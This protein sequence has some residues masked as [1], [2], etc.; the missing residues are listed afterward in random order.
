MLKSYKPYAAILLLLIIVIGGFV[1]SYVQL[2]TKKI[3]NSIYTH[4]AASMRKNVKLMI[5][6]KQKSTLAI[7]LSLANDKNLIEQI[8]QNKI[9]SDSYKDL[10]DKL[11][12]QTLY[13]NVWIQIINKD[14]VSL[15]RS[16]SDLKGDLLHDVRKDLKN[17]LLHKTVNYSI[18]ICRFDLSIRTIVPLFENKNFIGILEV[19]T[20]FNSIANS[21]KDS[22]VGSVVVVKKEFTDKIKFPLTNQ[23]INDHYVANLNAPE[24]LTNYLKT[25]GPTNYFNNSYKIEN[26]YII[27]SYELK[28]SQSQAIGYFIMFKKLSDVQTMNL[29][30]FVFKWMSVFVLLGLL[31][32]FIISNIILIKN[33]NQKK[34]YKSILDTASNIVIV[35]DGKKLVDTNKA[36][37]KYFYSYKTIDEFL[38]D[39]DCVC[40]LFAKEKGYLQQP[41]NNRYWIEYVIRNSDIVHKAKILYLDE[42]YYFSVTAALISED[43]KHY[44]VVLSDITKEEQYQKELLI[45]SIKDTLT[46]IY[47]RHYFDQKIDDEIFRVKRYEYPLSLIMLDIDFFKNVNDDHGHDVGDSVLI[48]YTKLISSL[49]RKTDIFCRMGGEEFII[50]LPHT[51]INEAV[52][53]SEKL[54]CEIEKY[55]KILPITMS[56]GVT[57]YKTDET[58]QTFLKRV[59][60]ALYKAKQS[61]RNKVIV[62]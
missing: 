14:A 20:H 28:N 32:L 41:M 40:D 17:I 12:Q 53:I 24:N 31:V 2:N 45:L 19:I 29:E 8:K 55:K 13:K 5:L 52:G 48:E 1:F 62:S 61:G 25:H 18:D 49:L 16:W 7:A 51:D 42:I 23:F 37:F 9:A 21:L 26:G 38:K 36:F 39:Y 47:N 3:Q 27:V 60:E 57:Q 30:F 44:S 11:T 46:D 43:P 6:Q 59:D 35:N 50:I 22:K 34:Y 54:R 56:F 15:Y 10:L 58:V 33:R 4:E